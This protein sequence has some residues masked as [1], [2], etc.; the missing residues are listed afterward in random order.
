MRRLSPRLIVVAAIIAATLI[1]ARAAFAFSDVP[2]S[3]WDY[4]AIQYVAVTNTWMQDYGPDI[5]QPTTKETR[6]FLARALV[7][8]Y[9]PDEPPDPSITFPDLPPENPLYPFA[10][11]A[12]KLGWI[13]KYASGEFGPSNAVVGSLLD[14]SLIKATGLFE[15]PLAGLAAIHEADGTP[16]VVSG[17]WPHMMLAHYLG[18]HYNHSNEKRDFGAKS[19]VNRDEVAYSLWR[20]KTLPRYKID[21][22]VKFNDITLAGLS[23]AQ[24]VKHDLTQ[25]AL[26]QVGYPYIWAG[27]WNAKSPSGY[28]CGYQ[29][30]GGFDCSGFV[31]WVMK[32]YEDGYNAAKYR[33]YAG[34]SIHDRSSSYMAK[35]AGTQITFGKLHV[36]DLMFFSSNGGKKWSDVNHVGLY[37]G[38][39]WMIH[40]SGST[41]GPVVEWVTDGYY[42]DHFVYGRRIIGVPP[43]F[44]SAPP[45]QLTAGDSA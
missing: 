20:A 34:W 35:N 12:V 44:I 29:P 4:T 41:D 8:A 37:V 1:P 26:D 15:A 38:K 36:G 16:Y 23:E 21:S 3:Y 27:E 40:S 39:G 30:Q 10:N 13:P 2:K 33:V 24:Q 7:L 22:T 17:R 25:E 32:R 5:F 43:K 18:L 42:R 31:W 14:S 6:G 45:S 9:A 28:C 11:V 19:R